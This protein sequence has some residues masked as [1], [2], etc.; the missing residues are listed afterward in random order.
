MNRDALVKARRSPKILPVL[1]AGKVMAGND[2][3]PISSS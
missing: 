3:K 1:L 2:N